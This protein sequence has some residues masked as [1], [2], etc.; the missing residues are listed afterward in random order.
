MYVTYLV[1]TPEK[2][3]AAIIKPEIARRYWGHENVSD[4]QPGSKWEHVRSDPERAVRI[5]GTVVDNDPPKRLAITWA[6]V[7]DAADPAKHSRVTFELLPFEG[8]VKLTVTHDEL[9]EGSKMAAYI[10]RGGPVVPCSL[11]PFLETGQPIDVFAVP[12]AN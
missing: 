8:M 12:K 2:I 11:K 4:W 5:T 6:S 10:G 9:V 3:F 1:S 7:A